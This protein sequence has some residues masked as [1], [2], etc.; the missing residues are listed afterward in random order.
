MQILLRWISVAEFA[1]S[2][3]GPSTVLLW[4]A[5]VTTSLTTPIH[6]AATVRYRAGPCS[7]QRALK[8]SQV[9]VSR[10]TRIFV[11]SRTVRFCRNLLEGTPRLALQ[12]STR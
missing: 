9:G 7:E 11:D 5:T 10:E 6:P 12:T 2:A 3:Q 4:P 1:C 8:V